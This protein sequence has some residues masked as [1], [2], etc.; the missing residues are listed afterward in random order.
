[1]T[2]MRLFYAKGSNPQIV[3]YKYAIYLSDP[4]KGQSQTKY[5][6]THGLQKS[7]DIDVEQI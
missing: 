2:D 5:L 3:G 6:F 7:R 4:Y 1:M